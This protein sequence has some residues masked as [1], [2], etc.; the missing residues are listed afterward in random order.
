MSRRK[1]SAGQRWPSPQSSRRSEPAS[2]RANHA[3]PN[4]S[5]RCAPH[6]RLER[7]RAQVRGDVEARV[8]V[9]EVV[10]RARLDLQRVA[11]QLDVARPHRGQVVRR[12]ELELVEELR[13]VAPHEE[14]EVRRA[15]GCELG[16][17]REVEPAREPHRI[18]DEVLA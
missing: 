18:V 13:A 17:P 16:R 8:D 5:R 11:E 4:C 10:D 3:L 1:S 9:A 12:V 6:L 14:E 15:L 7:P 2:R